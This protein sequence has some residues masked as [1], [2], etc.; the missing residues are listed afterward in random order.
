L[1]ATTLFFCSSYLRPHSYI[2]S[3]FFRSLSHTNS[4]L[5]KSSHRTIG[6]G[7]AGIV[8]ACCTLFP[9]YRGSGAKRS[10]TPHPDPL[11]LETAGL[12]GKCPLAAGAD[13]R[14][15][16]SSPTLDPGVY[17]IEEFVPL[18]G[19]DF[20]FYTAACLALSAANFQ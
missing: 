18:F 11:V 14:L 15:I 16:R 12:F 2:A 19:P 4:S 7:C 10:S 1:S 17:F 20:G 6:F 3:A 9:F 8:F 5:F 13:P